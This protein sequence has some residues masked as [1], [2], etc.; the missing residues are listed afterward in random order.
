MWLHRL[1]KEVAKE[2]VKYGLMVRPG[3]MLPDSS[4]GLSEGGIP[5]PLL[6][7]VG[8]GD[9]DDLILHRWNRLPEALKFDPDYAPHCD[10]WLSILEADR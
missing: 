2:F 3:C 5:V 1:G 9:R 8:T 6:P 7:D 4:W 10:A